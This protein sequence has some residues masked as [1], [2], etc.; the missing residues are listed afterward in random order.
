MPRAPEPFMLREPVEGD[1]WKS[2]GSRLTIQPSSTTGT[3]SEEGSDR[4][5]FPSL[6]DNDLQAEMR[7]MQTRMEMMNREMSRYL[8][9][10]AYESQTGTHIC[11]Q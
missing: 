10:P 2:K 4:S 5:T 3:F 1:R 6:S 9:P 11:A 7:E 8:V